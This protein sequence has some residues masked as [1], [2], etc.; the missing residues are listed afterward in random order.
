MFLRKLHLLTVTNIL[1]ILIIM[2]TV[3]CGEDPAGPSTGKVL[4]AQVSGDSVGTGLGFASSS[5]SVNSSQ[6]DF[7]DRDS[8]DINYNYTGT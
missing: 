7:T 6:I 8:V 3:S 1:A 4:V 5:L 2:F